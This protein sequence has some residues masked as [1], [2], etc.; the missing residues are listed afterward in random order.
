MQ[1]TGCHYNS[2]CKFTDGSKFVCMDD[3]LKDI[4]NGECLIYTFGIA[5]DWSFEDFMDSLGCEIYAFDGSVDY[6]E[7]RGQGIHFEKVFVGTENI[8]SENTAA[9]SS[10]MGKYGH[11]KTKISYLKMDIEGN[12]LNGLPLWLAE[13]SLDYV[14]QIGLEFHLDIN[15]ATTLSFIQ[16]L[17]ELYFEGEYRLISYEGNGC[18]KN[19]DVG[20][21]REKYFYLAEVV[22]KKVA[23]KNRCM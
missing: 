4:M 9:L 2:V 19:L 21:A 7:K 1:M 14:Q 5:K 11:T 15:I 18:A 16:T 23:L 22:F 3:L 8:D 20:K 10:L 17:K 12:E 13:G 6:P